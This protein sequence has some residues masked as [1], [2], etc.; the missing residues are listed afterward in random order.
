VRDGTDEI[1]TIRLSA[2]RVNTEN[3]SELSRPSHKCY[4]RAARKRRQGPQAR[5]AGRSAAKSL[6]EA[7]PSSTLI[8]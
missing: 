8:M 6:D 7:E 4:L 1:L 2:A 3:G 5:A